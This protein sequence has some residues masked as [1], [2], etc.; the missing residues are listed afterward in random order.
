[1]MKNSP[2]RLMVV[3]TTQT[4]A[5]KKMEELV[6]SMVQKLGAASMTEVVPR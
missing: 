5:K 4:D 2:S 1:M 3:V 6:I